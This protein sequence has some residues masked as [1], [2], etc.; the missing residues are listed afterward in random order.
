MDIQA[1]FGL[2]VL[3]GFV[4][5]GVVARM[6]V[7]PALQKMDRESAL[8]PLIVPHIFRFVGLS[9]LMPGVVSPQLPKA[10]AAPAAYG[11]LGAALLALAALYG[12]RQRAAW[13]IPAVWVFNVWGTADLLFAFYQGNAISL[14]PTWL[15]AA[16]YIPTFVVPLLLVLHVMIFML[17][18]RREPATR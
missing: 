11:D 6:Y 2:S 9:F 14:D 16:F 15:G 8:A 3:M 5:F 4:A 12:L 1:I 17:L 18:L 13:A 10:F 7:W